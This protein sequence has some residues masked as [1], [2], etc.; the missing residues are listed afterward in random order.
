MHV[1]VCTYVCV[2]EKERCQ[3]FCVFVGH[4]LNQGRSILV[5]KNLK[6][7]TT[8]FERKDFDYCVNVQPVHDPE[9]PS[10]RDLQHAV[11]MADAHG[12]TDAD[13]RVSHLFVHSSPKLGMAILA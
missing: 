1:C 4:I 13:K 6:R 12:F 11:T 8:L 10:K 5:V 9:S 3:L 2:C 7:N